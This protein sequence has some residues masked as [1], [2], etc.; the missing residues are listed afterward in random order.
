MEFWKRNPIRS[1][2]YYWPC[3]FISIMKIFSNLFI[4]ISTVR[5]LFCCCICII[6]TSSA[7]NTNLNQSFKFIFYCCSRVV[8][9]FLNLRNS[10]IGYPTMTIIKSNPVIIKER[11]KEKWFWSEFCTICWEAERSLL[12]KTSIAN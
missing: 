7:D 12:T 8:I 2:I 5:V 6:L 9:F 4:M 1:V 10:L 11:T 3:R